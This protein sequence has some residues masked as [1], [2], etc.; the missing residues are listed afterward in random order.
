MA[1]S[2]NLLILDEPTNHLDIPAAER[3]EGILARGTNDAKTGESTEPVFPGTVILISHDRALLDAVCDHLIVL[4]AAGNATV[5]TGTYSDYKQQAER[6]AR[7]AAPG[8]PTAKPNTAPKAAPKPEPPP[9]QS[10]P[11]PKPA[12]QAAPTSRG[13]SPARSVA[14]QP[15]KKS[16]FSWMPLNAIEQRIAE[17]TAKLKQTDARLA[18]PDVWKD[19]SKANRLTEERDSIRTELDDLEFEWI[20]KSG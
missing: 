3:L 16:K 7:A 10:K 6:A 14:T 1:S 2:K 18:N 9:P 19:A 17:L 13:S 8:K 15:E 5:F 12:P 11:Q 20:R 4:D